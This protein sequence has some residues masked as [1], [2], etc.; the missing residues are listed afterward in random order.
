MKDIKF[1]TNAP[2]LLAGKTL[3]VA[4]LHIGIEQEFFRS[5]IRIPSQTDKIKQKICS[6]IKATG[7]ERLVILGDL[8]HR[9]PGT[10]FQEEREIPEFLD[11][12]S[13]KIRA[14]EI[15][16]GNHDCGLKSFVDRKIKI[17]PNRGVFLPKEKVYLMHGHSWPAGGFLRAKYVIIGHSHPQMEFKNKLG[18]RWRLPVWIR[19]ELDRKKLEKRFGAIKKAPELIIMPAFSEIAG[20]K[21]I[22]AYKDGNKKDNRYAVPLLKCIDWKRAKTFLLDGTEVKLV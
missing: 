18:Y 5:G 15:V 3:V 10:S 20:G 9:I 13:R 14:V 4:D 11:R 17:H 8:K 1:V 22:N 12:L 19:T 2:A 21:A 7:T 6:I 16:P